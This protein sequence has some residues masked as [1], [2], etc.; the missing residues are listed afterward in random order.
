MFPR[1]G[2]LYVFLSEAYGAGVGLPVRL[3]VPARDSHRQRRHGGRGVRG[4]LQLLLPVARHRP[5][6]SPRSPM[7]WGAWSISAGQLVAAGSIAV[8][9]AINYVGVRSG[10]LR[11][12]RPDGGQGRR[13][14]RDPVAGHRLHARRPGADAGG[15]ARCAAP[16]GV[17]RRHHDRGDVDLRGLVLRGVCGG[18]DQG[19]GA[20]RAARADLR[21]AGADGHLRQREPRLR[22]LAHHRRRCPASPGSPRER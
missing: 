8:I 19:R 16:A 15:A 18:G 2:G 21:H 22:L 10:N 4:V 9:T 6:C 5:A 7:P 12:H 13:P 17:V 11:E 20:K 3:G 1:S 14:G